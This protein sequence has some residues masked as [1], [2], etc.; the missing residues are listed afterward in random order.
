M[1]SIVELHKGGKISVNSEGKGKGSTFT[2]TLAIDSQTAQSSQCVRDVSYRG[3]IP[4]TEDVSHREDIYPMKGW[5]VPHTG[6]VPHNGDVP[7]TQTGIAPHTEDVSD[8]EDIRPTGIVPQTRDL[9]PPE[10][11]SFFTRL[12][13]NGPHCADMRLQ[14]VSSESGMKL[15]K[16]FYVDA[17]DNSLE[18]ESKENLSKKKIEWIELDDKNNEKEIHNEKDTDKDDEDEEEKDVEKL[19]NKKNSQLISNEIVTL[20]FHERSCHFLVV[21]DSALNRK[22]LCKLL[23]AA[24]HT[25]AEA[26]DGVDALEK[27]FH[28]NTITS[29]SNINN[30]INY[31]VKN[32]IKNAVKKEVKKEIKNE[33]KEEINS[34]IYDAILMDFMMPNMDGPTATKFLR[35][36]GYNG[37]ILGITGHVLPSDIDYFI[38]NGANRV[39]LK[40][41]DMKLLQIS[42]KD[43]L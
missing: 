38:A 30:K 43:F 12:I 19:S 2:L 6:N 16:D 20:P 26:V 25:C 3:N 31:E 42:L 5:N 32:E 13:H 4:R 9:F 22:M 11:S 35:E 17:G 7:H 8:R 27:V 15:V 36:S 10:N 21:D 18:E 41:L 37:I 29:K 39:L 1:K 23:R 40:P 28:N 24:N 34:E 33:I 14:S